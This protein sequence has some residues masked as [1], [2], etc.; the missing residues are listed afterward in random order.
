MEG[1]IEM[2]SEGYFLMFYD[3]IYDI[4]DGIDSYK[5]MILIDFLHYRLR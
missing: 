4:D 1:L 2:S 3:T 5:F